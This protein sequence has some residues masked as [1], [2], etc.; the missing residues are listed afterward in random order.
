MPEL[1]PANQ[2]R[3]LDLTDQIL[4]QA[5]QYI[6]DHGTFVD[7][8]DI[9]GKGGT[10][11]QR[12]SNATG[13]GEVRLL[14]SMLRREMGLDQ[15]TATGTNQVTAIGTPSFLSLIQSGR[16]ISML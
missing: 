6:A 2:H 1:P 5:L 10:R 9:D 7:V 13:L 16:S 4:E 8:E 15:T 14:R 12:L 3:L 11:T